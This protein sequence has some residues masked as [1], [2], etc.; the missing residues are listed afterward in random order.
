MELFHETVTEEK[1]PG[2]KK[3]CIT[4]RKRAG[5][6]EGGLVGGSCPLG[7]AGRGLGQ[8]PTALQRVDVYM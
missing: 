3:I 6:S 5:R 4:G 1:R 7:R 8:Y 2:R